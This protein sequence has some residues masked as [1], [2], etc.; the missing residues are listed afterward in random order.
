MGVPDGQTLTGESV[1]SGLASLA[2]MLRFFNLPAD[3]A[4]MHHDYGKTD[5][6][7]DAADL[8]RCAKRGGLL[9]RLAKG[10]WDRLGRAP[11]PAIAE[12]TDGS[13]VVFARLLAEPEKGERLL[14]HDPRFR[15]PELKTREEIE[16]A[17]TGRMIYLTHREALAGPGRGFDLSWFIPAVVRYRRL[18]FE[19]LGASFFIQLMGLI[20]PLFEV[21]LGVRP[22]LCLLPHHQ[23]YRRR[24]RADRWISR[25][26]SR[27]NFAI[28]LQARKS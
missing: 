3:V 6:P 28:Y 12:M 19:V 15:S 24:T 18:L 8:V 22:L 4:Q 20:S 14:I 1:D 9:A 27:P 11:L 7:L 23:S 21:L 13:F 25:P 5:A 2:L 10:R 17:W 26:P 16:A